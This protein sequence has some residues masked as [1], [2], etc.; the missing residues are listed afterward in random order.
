MQYMKQILLLLFLIS[1]GSAIAE[2]ALVDTYSFSLLKEAGAPRVVRVINNEKGIRSSKSTERGV[3]FTYNDRKASDVQIAGDFS[4]WR[5]VPMQ[6][7]SH[8]VWFYFLSEYETEHSVRYKFL[9][10]GI[11][12]YDP[13]NSIQSDDGSG[14]YMSLTEA[15]VSEED[16]HVTF[17][18]VTEEGIDYIEFR[19]YR[20]EASFVSVVGDFNNWNPEN[21]P[22]ERTQKGIWKKKINISPGTYRYKFIVDGTWTVDLYNERSGSDG[23][24]GICSIITVKE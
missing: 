1:I 11:W 7:G 2:E 18:K 3:L 9:I 17:R 22:L 24:D 20:P 13:E 8:G 12:S 15:A 21:D 6:R 19:T 4:N 10:D 16:R 14:S 23:V 5:P